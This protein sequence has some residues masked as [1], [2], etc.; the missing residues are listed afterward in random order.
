M[1]TSG[2]L[3]LSVS[4]D[5]DLAIWSRSSKVLLSRL[6]LS[7]N[8]TSIK[9][10]GDKIFVGVDN[11][12]IMVFLH[13]GRGDIV[14]QQSISG[15]VGS[16][17]AIDANEKYFVTGGKDRTL[18]VWSIHDYKLVKQMK[19]H[20]SPVICNEHDRLGDPTFHR[21]GFLTQYLYGS[22]LMFPLS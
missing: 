12:N 21:D 6:Q 7:V 15:H 11:G 17:T 9:M 18:K 4:K 5:M 3:L 13:M 14:H 19:E 8:I 10:F 1:D 16:V 22:L 20:L 2:D